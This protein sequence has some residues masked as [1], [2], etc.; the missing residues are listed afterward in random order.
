MDKPIAP[1]NLFLL[2]AEAIAALAETDSIKDILLTQTNLYTSQEIYNAAVRISESEN[3]SR[4]Q[5]IHIK[6]FTASED[7]INSII[8]GDSILSEE[9]AAGILCALSEQMDVLI[10]DP[11]KV[12]AIQKYG[13]RVWKPEEILFLSAA[14]GGGDT[15]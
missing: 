11:R 6:T 15:H 5:D 12:A 7:A 8:A 3:L 13:L 14:F 1:E 10:D 9:E 4:L 2:D